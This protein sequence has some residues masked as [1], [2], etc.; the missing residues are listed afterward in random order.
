MPQIV[1]ESIIRCQIQ[2][3]LHLII[4]AGCKVCMIYSSF[5]KIFENLCKPKQ[6]A[7]LAEIS[8]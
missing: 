6:D 5:I 7:V 3:T 1:I 4:N 2:Q 8:I